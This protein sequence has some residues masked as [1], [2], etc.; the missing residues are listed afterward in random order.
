MLHGLA[1]GFFAVMSAQRRLG[2]RLRSA[3]ASLGLL[4]CAAVLVHAT[5]GL[6]E[7]HFSFFVLIG[8]M[9]L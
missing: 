6:T 8:L 5:H 7:A 2:R 9:T 3:A 4:T 1:P